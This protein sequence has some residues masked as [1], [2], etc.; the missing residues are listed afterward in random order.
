MTQYALDTDIV[1]YYLKGNKT[2]IGRV[3]NEAD[4]SNQYL[5]NWRLLQHRNGNSFL[6]GVH[7]TPVLG[8]LFVILFDK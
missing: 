5:K 1:T 4:N 6:Y 3:A 8:V 2:I 7:F